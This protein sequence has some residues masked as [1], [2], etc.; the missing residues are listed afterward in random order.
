MTTWTVEIP[1]Q[2]LSLGQAYR[3]HA[4]PMKR[5][6]V[7]LTD[8]KGRARVLHRPGLTDKAVAYRDKAQWLMQSARPSGW[9]P[10]GQ[11]RVVIDIRCLRP[12]DP[13]NTLKLLMDALKM[14][15]GHDDR[16]FLPVV[17]SLQWHAANPGVT[18]TITTDTVVLPA[19]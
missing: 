3:T 9:H 16:F 12:V 19:L 8:V 7:T 6:G 14:A 15:I 4:I 1:G 17:R 5:R 10:S 18:L 2:P 11:L 13:D